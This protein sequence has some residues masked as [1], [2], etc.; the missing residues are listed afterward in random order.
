MTERGRTAAGRWA[1]AGALA[2][3]LLLASAACGGGA[4]VAVDSMAAVRPEPLGLDLLSYRWKWVSTDRRQEVRPQEFAAA[5]VWADTIYLGGARGEFVALRA[6][7]GQPRWSKRLGAVHAAPTVARGLLYVGTADGILV[8][9]D[10]LSGEE[11]WRYASQGPI[12]Q[13]P[14]VAGNLVLFGNEADQVFALDALTGAYKWKYKGET[15]EEYTLRG[16]AGLAVADD[17][18]FTGFAN[19]TLVALRLDTGSV[20]WSTSLREDQDRF[21]DIDG[22]P[23]V[24]GGTV[25]ATASSGGLYAL[26]VST[27]LVRWRTPF[28]DAAAP[29][30]TGATGALSTDGERL[31]VAAADLGVYALDLDGNVLWRQGTRG[32]GE[33]AAP[34]VWGKLVIY[35]LAR[36]GMYLADRRTGEIYEFFNPGEGTAV[37]TVTADGQLYVLSNRGVLY[38]FD[39]DDV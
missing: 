9:L 3:A 7:D 25:Y 33:P 26:D 18:A 16:H 5:A 39:L 15:P 38:A 13:A 30:T 12:G 34:V 36:D 14:V 28:F 20:A 2:G 4:G 22:T 31:F 21:V 17:L 37:P 8:C 1:S 23:V 10:A 29:S 27:G 11:R 32:G 24:L 19:G 6:S 35:S